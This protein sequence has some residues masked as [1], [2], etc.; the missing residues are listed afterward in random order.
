MDCDS[1]LIPERVVTLAAIRQTEQQEKSETN[2]D[3][4]DYPTKR[5]GI[6]SAFLAPQFIATLAEVFAFDMEGATETITFLAARCRRSLT[7]I[8]PR[9]AWFERTLRAGDHRIWMPAMGTGVR[10]GGQ[11]AVAFRTGNQ[12][13]GRFSRVYG[14]I[15]NIKPDIGSM[16]IETR[17]ISHP[18]SAILLT[19]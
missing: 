17:A 16:P 18:Y 3:Q 7:R 10:C 6:G 11:L 14:Y 15:R 2:S 19:R 1:N 12:R 5:F 9:F 8:T 13:H 4:E